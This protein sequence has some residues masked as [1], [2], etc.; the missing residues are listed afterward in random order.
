MTIEELCAEKVAQ[1]KAE[2]AKPLSLS[3]YIQYTRNNLWLL[4][5]IAFGLKDHAP[6]AASRILGW[7]SGMR[8]DLNRL[9]K[10]S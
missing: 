1:A 6:E 9:G 8:Q 2:A 7:V 10:P 3:E 5:G 4:E